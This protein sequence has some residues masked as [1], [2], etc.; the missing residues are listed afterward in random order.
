MNGSKVYGNVNSTTPGSQLA[1]YGSSASLPTKGAA[2]R[3]RMNIAN[4]GPDRWR[5]GFGTATLQYAR[6]TVSDCSTQTG[7]ADVQSGSGDIRWNTNG[8][9]ANNTAISILAGD[10][11]SAS[12]VAETYRSANNFTPTVDI[13]SGKSGQWDFSLIEMAPVPGAA[14]CFKVTPASGITAIS[15]ANNAATAVVQSV[16][17]LDVDIV[18]GSGAAVANPLVSFGLLTPSL[19]CQ[20]SSATLGTSIQKIRLSNGSASNGWSVSIAATAGSTALWSSGAGGRYD[21]NDGSGSPAGC[22]DGADGDSYAGQL[23][24]N[25]SVATITP[26]SGCSATGVTKG[27]NATFSEG[28]VN[29]IALLSASSSA[30]MYCYWDMTS[31]PL[32]QRVPA[33]VPVGTYTLDLTITAVAS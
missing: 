4:S 17:T 9:V 5:A 15:L 11:K 21:F 2:F 18:D 28:A 3:L 6:K 13:P 26:M 27:S 30:S 7:Y 19:A 10:S 31:I 12:L 24:V 23:S 33:S 16:G 8:S 14:Y 22:G 20:Q 32:S 1:D 25:P 29:S